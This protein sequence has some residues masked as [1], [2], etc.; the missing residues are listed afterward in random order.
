M[1]AWT[2]LYSMDSPLSSHIL[3]PSLSLFSSSPSLYPLS[4]SHPLC[5]L[6]SSFISHPF[7]FL[8]HPA[9]PPPSQLTFPPIAPLL[10]SHLSSVPSPSPRLSSPH[11][12]CRIGCGGWICGRV[13]QLKQKRAGGC[14]RP[15]H[16]AVVLNY[17]TNPMS[18][19]DR[20]YCR[21]RPAPRERGEGSRNR[22]KRQSVSM[23]VCV[24]VCVYLHV[25]LYV[26]MCV[27]FLVRLN[28]WVYVCWTD[29]R[30]KSWL[31]GIGIVRSQNRHETYN[32]DP[33]IQ[34]P[35]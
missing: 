35:W 17:N 27:C 21:D 13:E 7:S 30:W 3:L 18:R 24:C 2:Q 8:T 10:P 34:N 9:S 32:S 4:Q 25:L 6:I 15:W 1:F 33:D 31:I 29:R 22:A 11:L 23:C 14:R 12:S 20:N 19:N 5:P 16:W 26:C 28:V